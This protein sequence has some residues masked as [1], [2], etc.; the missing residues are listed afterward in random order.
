MEVGFQP[1]VACETKDEGLVLVRLSWNCLPSREQT[2]QKWCPTNLHNSI[3]RGQAAIFLCGGS[4]SE[5]GD[6]YTSVSFSERLVSAPFD[7][8]PIATFAQKKKRKEKEKSYSV[9]KIWPEHNRIIKTCSSL[10]WYA[11]ET[12]KA[13]ISC[14]WLVILYFNVRKLTFKALLQLRLIILRKFRRNRNNHDNTS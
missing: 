8:E 13:I 7:I 14:S 6:V 3:S 5:P 9:V 10:I 1:S 4:R 2:T 11:I 12:S